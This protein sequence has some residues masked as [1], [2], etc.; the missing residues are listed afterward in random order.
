MKHGGVAPLFTM[1]ITWIFYN[2]AMLRQITESV[3]IGL[4][5]ENKLINTKAKWNYFLIPRTIINTIVNFITCISRRT[6]KKYFLK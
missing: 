1:N 5:K 3:R 2:D 6:K 4:V